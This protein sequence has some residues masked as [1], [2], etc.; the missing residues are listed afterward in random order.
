MVLLVRYP[1]NTPEGMRRSKQESPVELLAMASMATTAMASGSDGGREGWRYVFEALQNVRALQLLLFQDTVTP[2][3]DCLDFAAVVRHGSLRCTWD[4][5]HGTA[6]S[7][8]VPLPACL[9]DLSLPT[10]SWT[11]HDHVEVRLG[12]LSLDPALHNLQMSLED[13]SSN[14]DACRREDSGGNPFSVDF[15]T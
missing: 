3:Q 11:R 1:P 6:K 8:S 12:L 9:L 15:G 10:R 4:S 14:F 2:A 13:Q 7:L 5:P